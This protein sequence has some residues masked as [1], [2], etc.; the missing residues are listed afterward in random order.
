MLSEIVVIE[1]DM[2]TLRND[3]LLGIDNRFAM[4]LEKSIR[5]DDCN[6]TQLYYF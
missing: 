1:I 5:Y 6:V 3:E 2:I 4:Y